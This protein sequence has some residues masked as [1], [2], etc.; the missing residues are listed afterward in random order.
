MRM[1]T[2]YIPDEDQGIL[3]CQIL[4]PTGATLEQ[5]KGVAND[6]QRYFQEK[7]K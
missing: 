7:E 2:G 3:L 6:V 1:P 4:M 5:T